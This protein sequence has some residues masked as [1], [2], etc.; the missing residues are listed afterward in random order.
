VFDIGGWRLIYRTELDFEN[1]NFSNAVDRCP[2][3]PT[4]IPAPPL[5]TALKYILK[6]YLN[7]I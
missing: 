4:G 3:E 6:V 2:L 5:A 7:S 1:E